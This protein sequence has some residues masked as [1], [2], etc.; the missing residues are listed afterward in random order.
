M[1]ATA[2]DNARTA[3]RREWVGLAVL[4]LPTLLVSMDVTALYLA[5]PELPPISPPAALSCCGSPTSTGS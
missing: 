3:T 5:V 2:P 4:A 1:K